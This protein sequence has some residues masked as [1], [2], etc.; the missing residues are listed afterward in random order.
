MPMFQY[1][2]KS[3]RHPFSLFEVIIVLVIVGT[4]LGLVIPRLGQAAA[5]INRDAFFKNLNSA[6]HMAS[7]MAAATGSPAH[8]AFDPDKQLIR[9]TEKGKRPATTGM[10]EAASAGSIFDELKEFQ[11]PD[12]TI[13]EPTTDIRRADSSAEYV[14]YPNGEATGPEIV[15]TIG[16]DL[17]LTLDVD[18]LTGSPIIHVDAP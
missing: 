11:L 8:L 15:L 4:I 18:R 14:F 12:D 13:V 7:S 3:K 9:V 17:K 5:R 16:E 1:G 2:A 6:F 10:D